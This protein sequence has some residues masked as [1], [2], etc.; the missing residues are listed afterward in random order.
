V[1]LIELLV[2]IVMLA[3]AG[4]GAAVG[5]VRG[6]SPLVVILL[7][8]GGLMAVP[9]LLMLLAKIADLVERIVNGPPVPPR[10]CERGCAPCELTPERVEKT[11]VWRCPC[12]LSYVM[13]APS[14]GTHEMRR[15]SAGHEIPYLRRRF[16]WRWRLVEARRPAAYR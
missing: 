4:A 13:R 6:A 5:V 10:P 2:L 12:G 16:W 11:T 14:F 8:V 1:T 15:W 9:T 3:L 7:T